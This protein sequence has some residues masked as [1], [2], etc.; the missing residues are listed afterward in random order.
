MEKA[1][2]A[3]ANRNP[4]DPAWKLGPAD[5]E[6][7]REGQVKRA[8]GLFLLAFIL[9]GCMPPPPPLYQPLAENEYQTYKNGRV[10]IWIDPETKCEYLGSTL[11][12]RLDRNGKQICR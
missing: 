7:G 6:T 8:S 11:Q 5:Q 9:A 3:E 4:E 10:G 12:P 2:S 1:L